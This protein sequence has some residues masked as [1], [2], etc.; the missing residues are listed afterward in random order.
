[1]QLEDSSLQPEALSLNLDA[2]LIFIFHIDIE[3]ITNTNHE[4]GSSKRAAWRLPEAWALKLEACLVLILI[5]TG[6]VIT[7]TDNEL[8]A[9]SLQPE[10]CSLKLEAM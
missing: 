1:M 5:L 6:K 2:C 9:W 10:G 7:N 4:A 3:I 8:E